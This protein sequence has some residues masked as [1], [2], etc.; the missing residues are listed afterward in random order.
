MTPVLRLDVIAAAAA[1]IIRENVPGSITT[2][3]AEE[4]LRQ[5]AK[6]TEVIKP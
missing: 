1:R 3:M 4:I 2:V 5:I 6:L